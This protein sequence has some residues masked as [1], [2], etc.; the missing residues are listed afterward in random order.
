[1]AVLE[2]GEAV[3]VR[4][5]PEQF[6]NCQAEYGERFDP[7]G[8]APAHAVAALGF[9]ADFEKSLTSETYGIQAR[10]GPHPGFG[11]FSC[12]DC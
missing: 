8:R 11:G 12:S 9:H 6:G 5:R 1:M 7:A 3:L 2:R 10:F 4:V